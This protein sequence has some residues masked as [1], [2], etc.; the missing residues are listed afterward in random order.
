MLPPERAHTPQ[1]SH[2]PVR[3]LPVHTGE[4]SDRRN[5][6]DLITGVLSNVGV[7]VWCAA[8]AICFYTSTIL[9]YEEGTD[10]MRSFLCWSGLI[11]SVLLLFT[12]L[13]FFALSMFADG[14]QE[15]WASPWRIVFEDGFTLLGIVSWSSYLIRTCAHAAAARTRTAA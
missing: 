13:T 15:Q 7:L 5:R 2:T 8:A 11:S 9:R 14:F 1:Y 6:R 12:G 3:L 4:R 10:E